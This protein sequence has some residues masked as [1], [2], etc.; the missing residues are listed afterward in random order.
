MPRAPLDA[1]SQCRNA[2]PTPSGWAKLTFQQPP[3][4]DPEMK[5]NCFNDRLSTSSTATRTSTKILL[6]STT[7]CLCIVLGEIVLRFVGFHSVG[8]L[9]HPVAK[10]EVYQSFVGNRDGLFVANKDFHDRPADVQSMPKG[11]ERQSLPTHKDQT[12]L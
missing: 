5:S 12:F 3:S 11:L 9:V 2:L 6:V 7:F 8:E 4:G 10:L 1:H